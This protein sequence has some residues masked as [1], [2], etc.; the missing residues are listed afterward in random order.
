MAIQKI[1]LCS[2]AI[3]ATWAYLYTQDTPDVSTDLLA[4]ALKKIGFE[5]SIPELPNHITEQ[6]KQLDS[7]KEVVAMPDVV[8]RKTKALTDSYEKIS[9]TKQTLFESIAQM[10][11]AAQLFQ[12]SKNQMLNEFK[13]L[14]TDLLAANSFEMIEPNKES[15][16]PSE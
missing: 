14:P 11:D 9:S 12:D 1:V 10:K 8:D 13:D 5:V 7:L 6:W 16:V 2:L 3:V 15:M 4:S